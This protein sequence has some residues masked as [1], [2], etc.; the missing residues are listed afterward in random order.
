MSLPIE[1]QVWS[2]KRF[3]ISTDPTLLSLSAINKAFG[4]E[5]IY[6]ARPVPEDVLQGII[7]NSFCFGLY[8][9]PEASTENAP[10]HEGKSTCGVGKDMKQIGFARLVGDKVTFAYL[11]DLYV[12]PAYQGFGLGGWL[13]DCV[14]EVLKPL[15][16]LRWTML[17]TSVEKSQES[18][19][20]RLGMAVL[21]SGHISD[22]PVMMGRKGVAGGP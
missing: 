18:Y 14:G 20:K 7:D 12:L 10:I 3:M 16:H 6:W 17:R 21:K 15:P 4:E 13:I 8:E 5:F 1:P 22:G 2:R 11:T 19:E 9:L